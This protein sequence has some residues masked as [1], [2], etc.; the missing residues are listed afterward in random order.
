MQTR[1]KSGISKKKDF[2]DFQCFSTCLSTITVL[3]E[4]LTFREASTKSEW[5]QAMTEE[6]QALQTQGTW[7]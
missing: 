6:I 5:Q 1:L 7:D 3:D 2:G 4:P